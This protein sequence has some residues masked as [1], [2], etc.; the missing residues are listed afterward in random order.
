[1]EGD[2]V[3]RTQCERNENA[4][5]QS[6]NWA[7]ILIGRALFLPATGEPV[8]FTS[9]SGKA[10]IAASGGPKI[11]CTKGTDTGEITSEET[12]NT[13]I[14]FSECTVLGIVTAHSLGDAA[15]TIL[16]FS[17]GTLCEL[18]ESEHHVGLQLTPSGKLHIEGSGVLA[19]VEG[20]VI[21]EL[22]PVNKKS[23]SEE[24]VFEQSSEGVQKIKRCEGGSEEH[25][26][27]AENEGTAKGASME[28][29]DK[30]SAE[31]TEV[32]VMG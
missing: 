4:A 5:R 17:S 12:A 15:G 28:V 10:T 11:T 23:L 26:S 8:K 27:V 19:S 9:I 22:T 24:L 13:T 31:K 6:G 21:G 2:F 16:V 30:I 1:M 3:G 29:K 18:S 20:T 32:E 25:L 7:R 14:D